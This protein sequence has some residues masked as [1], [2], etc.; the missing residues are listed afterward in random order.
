MQKIDSIE[1]GERNQKIMKSEKPEMGGQN[2]VSNFPYKGVKSF[3][4]LMR[5][6]STFFLA[7]RGS[8]KVFVMSF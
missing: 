8:F 7:L 3:L 6:G 2:F 1:N 4:N 5:R